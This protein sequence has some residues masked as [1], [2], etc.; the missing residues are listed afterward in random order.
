MRVDVDL[1]KMLGKI[2]FKPKR[3]RASHV[4]SAQLDPPARRVAVQTMLG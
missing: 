3:Q 4:M 2:C 1:I